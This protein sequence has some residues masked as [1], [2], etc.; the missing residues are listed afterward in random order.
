MISDTIS[1]LEVDSCVVSELPFKGNIDSASAT[2]FFSPCIYYIS[3]P[4][5]S[6]IGIHFNTISVLNVYKQLFYGQCRLLI[7]DQVTQL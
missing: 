2:I 3:G 6:S 1:F 4:H 7:F 5:S